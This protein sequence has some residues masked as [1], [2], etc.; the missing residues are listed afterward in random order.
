MQKEHSRQGSH[1][2]LGTIA[3]GDLLAV[4][5]AQICVVAFDVVNQDVW[6]KSFTWVETLLA[7]VR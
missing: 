3:L 2:V 6:R 5:Q 7:Q 1:P 4:G